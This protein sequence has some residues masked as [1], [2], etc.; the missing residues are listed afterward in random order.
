MTTWWRA[1]QPGP[2]DLRPNCGQH[3]ASIADRTRAGAESGGHLLA[4][5]D[6]FTV[7]V[8]TWRGSSRTTCCSSSRSAVAWVSLGGILTAPKVP[9][10]VRHE[11][12]CCTVM[13]PATKRHVGSESHA[14]TSWEIKPFRCERNFSRSTAPG[15]RTRSVCIASVPNNTGPADV[16]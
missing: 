14:K 10:Q 7:E 16:T 13:L 4:G 2:S 5:T 3:F 12:P 6:F 9:E 1:L 15:R 8:L 11:A